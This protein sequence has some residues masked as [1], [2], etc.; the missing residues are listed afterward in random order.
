[1]ELGWSTLDIL[2]L[3]RRPE[4]VEIVYKDVERGKEE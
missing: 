1:M 4:D 2:Q 3:E